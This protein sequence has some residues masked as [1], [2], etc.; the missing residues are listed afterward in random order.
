LISFGT[1]DKN[2][3]KRE[4][5]SLDMKDRKVHFGYEVSENLSFED[6]TGIVHNIFK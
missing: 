5:Y 1:F 4:G 2:V 3:K 6:L